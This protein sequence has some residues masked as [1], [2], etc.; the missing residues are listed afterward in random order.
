MPA[1]IAVL[2]LTASMAGCVSGLPPRSSIPA[3][4]PPEVRENIGMLYW[5]AQCR[6]QGCLNLTRLASAGTDCSAAVPWLVV[7]LADDTY[8]WSP[9][10]LV[11][12]IGT[13]VHVEAHS[14]LRRI[15]EP[16]VP[17]L[18]EA[19]SHS[20]CPRTRQRAAKLLD[21]LPPCP[22]ANPREDP[23]AN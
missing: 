19:A 9:S 16:A 14:A 2:V 6:A 4:T 13:P 18:K 11:R 3:D 17:A 20:D 7:L 21:E 1:R 12:Y 22:Q 15:G 10:F 5:D 23:E 8:A